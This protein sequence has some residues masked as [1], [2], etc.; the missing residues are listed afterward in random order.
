MVEYFA[1]VARIARMSAACGYRSC[2][3][4]VVLDDP[5]YYEAIPKTLKQKRS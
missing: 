4:D 3:F 5:K 2:A 1:G